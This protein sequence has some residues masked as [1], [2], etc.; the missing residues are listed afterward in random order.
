MAGGI[1]P[2]LIGVAQPVGDNARPGLIDQD[3]EPVR[4]VGPP[5]LMARNVSRTDRDPNAILR[6]H[7]DEVGRRDRN[8]VHFRKK[9]LEE[10]RPVQ[11]PDPAIVAQVGNQERPTALQ[12]N[13]VRAKI[14]GW[15][16]RAPRL[17]GA[18][19]PHDRDAARPFRHEDIA[20]ARRHHAFRPLET[21][22]MPFECGDRDTPNH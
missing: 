17:S 9:W 22:A 7:G 3:D 14:E 4:N 13:P 21:S 20:G 18:V 10:S 8:A 6:V 1:R 2:D 5:G 11:P 19:R 15:R 16:A 12:G